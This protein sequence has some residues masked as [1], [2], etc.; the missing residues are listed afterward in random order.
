MRRSMRRRSMSRWR[1]KLLLR[2]AGERKRGTERKETERHGERRRER[3][4]ETGRETAERS[5]KWGEEELVG[6]ARNW[7]KRRKEGRTTRASE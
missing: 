4:G 1:E 6:Q 2:S 3:G 5:K 7:R